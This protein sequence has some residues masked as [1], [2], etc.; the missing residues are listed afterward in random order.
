MTF[1]ISL[2]FGIYLFSLSCAVILIAHNFRFVIEG[3]N[4]LMHMAI[5]HHLPYLQTT[6]LISPESPLSCL[7]FLFLINFT[8]LFALRNTARA[9]CDIDMRNHTAKQ[10]RLY[11]TD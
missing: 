4:G 9:C 3:L 7:V 2:P 1:H 10:L 11:L 5:R 8:V 6:S